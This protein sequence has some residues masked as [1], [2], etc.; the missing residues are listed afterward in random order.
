MADHCND[1]V[2]RRMNP[3]GIKPERFTIVE[4]SYG[5]G[6]VGFAQLQELPAQGALEFRSLVVL[7]EHRFVVPSCPGTLEGSQQLRVYGSSPSPLTSTQAHRLYSNLVCGTSP[8]A[9]IHAQHVNA[10]S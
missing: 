9:Q 10:T 5:A 1:A 8:V 2:L 3:L 6:V 4:D 7:P